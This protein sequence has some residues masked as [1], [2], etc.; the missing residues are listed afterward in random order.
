MQ[1]STWVIDPYKEISQALK[2][3]HNIIGNESDWII[4]KKQML[5]TLPPQVRKFF[6]TRDPVTKQQSMNEFDVQIAK[7]WSSMTKKPVVFKD[8]T[9]SAS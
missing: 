2:D 6:S 4:I 1:D 5:R 7:L 3:V 9:I 8:E